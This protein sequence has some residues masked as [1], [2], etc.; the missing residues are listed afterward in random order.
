MSTWRPCSDDEREE[1]ECVRM[2]EL[3]N[4]KG[5]LLGMVMQFSEDAPAY[6]NSMY[7][8]IGPVSTF[9]AAKVAVERSLESG[10]PR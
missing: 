10:S 9:D 1:Y 8:R 4:D 6:A 3:M 2:E 5:E 7:G